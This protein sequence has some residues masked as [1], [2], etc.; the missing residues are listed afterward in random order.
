MS[1]TYVS[2]DALFLVCFL[3]NYDQ[4]P[5]DDTKHPEYAPLS[6]DE[7]YEKP[8][9]PV[10]GSRRASPSSALWIV[11]FFL[12]LAVNIGCFLVT[13]RKV[14]AVFAALKGHADFLAVDQLPKAKVRH[15]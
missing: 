14:N 7:D 3:L 5:A 11:A 1:S 13:T 8:S 6:Q 2:V 4:Y 12:F 15:E 9:S 10:E